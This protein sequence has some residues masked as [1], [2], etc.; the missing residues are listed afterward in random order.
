MH[1]SRRSQ[2]ARRSAAD[3][4]GHG[5]APGCSERGILIHVAK[6]A[7]VREAG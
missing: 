1:E 2:V 5:S 3:A 6:R 4:V 7:D